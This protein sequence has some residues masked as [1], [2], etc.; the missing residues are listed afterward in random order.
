MKKLFLLPIAV[1]LAF[2]VS[3]EKPMSE[4]DRNAQVEREVQ[5]R[6]AAERQAAEE[7]RLAQQ[8]ADLQ[9]REQA[10]ADSEAAGS[11]STATSAATPRATQRAT[12]SSA[13][14]SR[15]GNGRSPRS[16]DTFYRKLEPHGA[17]RETADYGYVWQPR[18][19]QQSRNWRPYT[20]G[21]WAYTDAGWTWISDEPFGWATYHYGRWTRLRGVGWVWVPG[22][23]WAPAWVSWRTSDQHV[24]WAPL[25]PEARFE[26]R[27]GIK[28]WADSYYD[29]DVDEYVFIPNEEIGSRNISRAVVPV[30]RNVTIVNQTTNVTNITYSNTTVINEGPDYEQLRGRSR[31]P[32]RRM[33]IERQYDIEEEQSPR[34]SITGEVIAMMTPLFT[35]RAV[36][37]PQTVGAPI[38]QAAVERGPTLSGANQA[39]VERA[40]AKMRAEATPPPDAPPKRFEKPVVAEGTPEPASTAAAV[41]ASATPAPT[42]TPVATAT[43]SPQ[44]T[45]PTPTA[46]ATASPSPMPTSSPRST[47]VATPT[48]TP[49]PTPAVKETPTPKPILKETPT[50][51]ATS[52]PVAT[53]TATPTPRATATP[54]PS[55]TPTP[56][57]TATP[58]PAAAVVTSPAPTAPTVRGT[59]LPS[60]TASPDTDKEAEGGEDPPSVKDPPTANTALTGQDARQQRGTDR[61]EQLRKRDEARNERIRKMAEAVSPAPSAAPPLATPPAAFTPRPG[62]SSRAAAPT[63]ASAVTPEDVL[64][65]P[66]EATPFP[67]KPLPAATPP[68][69]TATATVAPLMTP[70][71]PLVTPSPA[72]AAAEPTPVTRKTTSRASDVDSDATPTPSPSPTP[73]APKKPKGGAEPSEDT[74]VPESPEATP[75]GASEP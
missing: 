13:S 23:E 48:A 15:S 11:R 62:L 16:Y 63:P 60:P 19:A 57:P 42:A 26:R 33:R 65:P 46:A 25:P 10:L 52:T 66:R 41:S 36:Q 39:E 44:A 74:D 38:Q 64:D 18:Q 75:E 35:A 12:T 73:N 24:G 27:T 59:P 7:E 69:A 22:E 43:H 30:E 37:R 3:C 14:S 71:R 67:K 53:V 2:A 58:T 54:I 21:R 5:Q 72:D 1:V 28:R 61:A 29:I 4:A 40:R 17:W 47:P 68:V 70:P 56:T 50:P 55:A 34:P 49:T 9:A 20:E 45:T 51:T 32:L 6:L 31:E 8:A